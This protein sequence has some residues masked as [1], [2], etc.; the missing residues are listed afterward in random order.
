M[1]KA[2]LICCTLSIWYIS[3]G[4]ESDTL[5]HEWPHDGGGRSHLPT[6]TSSSSRRSQPAHHSHTTSGSKALTRSPGSASHNRGSRTTVLAP[7]PNVSPNSSNIVANARSGRDNLNNIAKGTAGGGT[8]VSSNGNNNGLSSGGDKKPFGNSRRN[9]SLLQ[10]LSKMYSLNKHFNS[11]SEFK[12][13][14]LKKPPVPNQ[15]EQKLAMQKLEGWKVSGHK[16]VSCS[17]V[18]PLR[19]RLGVS[20]FIYLCISA[21]VVECQP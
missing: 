9:G 5:H 11:Y 2:N 7:I 14:E 10:S 15:A 20:L 16:V 6:N 4:D 13:K 19:S 12:V 3:D 1:S 17:F 18:L 21:G 8:S